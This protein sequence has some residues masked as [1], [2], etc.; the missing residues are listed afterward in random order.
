MK[1]IITSFLLLLVAALGMRATI[2]AT[3]EYQPGCYY[4]AVI[5]QPHY[6]NGVHL[7]VYGS[8]GDMGFRIY[9]QGTST[10]SSEVGPMTKIVFENT[11][12]FDFVFSSG[13]S[14]RSGSNLV[15][16]GNT[17]Q[18]TFTPQSGC[19]VKRIIVTV[20]DSGTP[21]PPQPVGEGLGKIGDLE[22][23]TIFT[24]LYPATVLWHGSNR[25]YLKDETGYG[26]VYG[27]VGR[28]YK[29]GD[30]I[31]AGWGG[32][33]NYY[34]GEPELTRPFFGF[35]EPEEHVTVE[36]EEINFSQLDHAHFAHYVV[37]HGVRIDPTR[38]VLI[39][40]DGNEIPYYN[41]FNTKLP[42]DT[43]KEYS[44]YGIVGSYKPS[45]G[46]I[47]Y[48]LLITDYDPKP[49]IQEID[50]LEDLYLLSKGT[51]A[52][53]KS[54]LVAIHQNGSYLYV[55]DKR[56]KYGLIYGSKA[57]GPFSN[58]DS[59]VGY[60]SWTIYQNN[61]Q[62]TPEDE[63]DVVG[64]GPVQQPVLIK[65]VEDV[66]M[67][68]VHM[69]VKFKD[70]TVT[71]GENLLYTMSDWTGE[72]ALYNRYNITIPTEEGFDGFHPTG[73]VNVDNE[74][75]IGDVMELIDYI[76]KGGGAHVTP[77]DQQTSWKHCTVT[78]FLSVYNYEPE[79]FPTEVT[80]KPTPRYDVNEDG[81]V[82]I[83]DVNT[84][85]DYI[86]YY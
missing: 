54:P 15:W 22:E 69:Y 63:W 27:D 3:F 60:A 44:F 36:A 11:N 17:E 9:N 42:D 78:G 82:N 6:N 10:L 77:P 56:G 23:G 40:R 12:S 32:T 85:I 84:L 26:L 20:D 67:D 24:S 2:T 30:V 7:S 48:Q 65:A 59:I 57:G 14:Y 33:V 4:P 50:Y 35:V 72:M 76:L 18:L 58:G 37:V 28:T 41:Q 73:D 81:E 66:E 19:T 45:G 43:S 16:T 51:V 74:L 53:F 61:P 62:L 79:L 39:D 38:R 70:V 71:Q 75:N 25:L 13:S 29:Q 5:P 64:H 34:G 80:I 47:I 83:S 21:P 68:W 49:E 52:Y 1:R 46:D 86:L 31:P 55:K 8:L